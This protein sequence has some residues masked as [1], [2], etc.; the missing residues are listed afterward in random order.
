MKT[1]EQKQTAKSVSIVEI[2]ASFGHVAT[3]NV[4]N[5]LVYFSPFRE[6]R[7]A[8]FFVC[9]KKNVFKDF[10]G[11]G[12][13]SIRLVMSL[14]NIGYPQAVDY[15]L[16]F[17]GSSLD[18]PNLEK[19]AMDENKQKEK[20]KLLQFDT[21]KN[22]KLIEYGRSRGIDTD[23]LCIYCCEVTYSNNGKRYSSLGFINQ[24]NS[25]ELRSKNF[26]ACL[27]IKD[28]SEPIN[29]NHS[30]VR[31]FEGFFDFLSYFQLCKEQDVL[32]FYDTIIV[33]NSL[34]MLHKVDF[35]RFSRVYLHLDND[36]PG[37]AATKKITETYKSKTVVDNSGLYANYKDLNEYLIAQKNK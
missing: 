2:L 4:G 26:Q 21:L 6:E 7:T 31:I 28:I 12:G 27:G 23:L 8:S 37:R 24:S 19:K 13:D 15:L 3:E 33:L 18:L 35:S 9:P 32:F 22:D 25:F 20:I 34:S 10:G 17:D 36:P 30:G 16:S 5:Q 14:K 29:N 1:E 11:F